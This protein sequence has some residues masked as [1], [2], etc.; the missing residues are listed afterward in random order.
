MYDTKQKVI[1]FFVVQE[2]DCS[3][4]T[5]HRI[6]MQTDQAAVRKALFSQQPTQPQPS[7]LSQSSKPTPKLRKPYHKINDFKQPEM[8]FKIALK[9]FSLANG[10]GVNRTEGM[11]KFEFKNVYEFIKW[12]GKFRAF[13]R[14]DDKAVSAVWKI[15]V[16]LQVL[17]E[18]SKRV[19]TAAISRDLLKATAVGICEKINAM[20][21]SKNAS[22]DTSTSA[23]NTLSKYFSQLLEC[24]SRDVSSPEELA[25]FYATFDTIVQ[26]GIIIHIEKDPVAIRAVRKFFSLR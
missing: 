26:R 4:I 6:A 11:G 12:P 16:W 22:K 17:A 9:K 1:F 23:P 21:M 3:R 13:D 2:G 19:E 20:N 5:Q 24:F 7:K 14:C 8:S 25:K 10:I 15:T 18:M